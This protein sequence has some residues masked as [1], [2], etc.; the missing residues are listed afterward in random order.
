MPPQTKPRPGIQSVE[1][2]GR[3][4]RALAEAGRPLPLKDLAKLARMHPGKCH[5]Y[6]V[7]LTRIELVTQD[8]S[9]GYYG[10]GPMAM[11]LGLAGLRNVDVVRTATPLLPALRDEVNETALLSIWSPKGPVVFTLEESERPVY[12]NVKVGS[13]LPL[14]TTA[15]GRVFA[16]F[17]PHDVTAPLLAEELRG[18]TRSPAAF[19]RVLEDVRRTGLASI[20]GDLVPGVNAVAAPL[21]DRKDRIVGVIGA[22][23]RS[24]DLDVSESGVVAKVLLRTAFEISRRMGRASQSLP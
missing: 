9:S 13:I 4:L 12:F 3:I 2:A 17:L 10:V 16:A 7:S 18:S 14:T 5:R 11:M 8:E 21:F 23:G 20:Q 15:T 6:L 19:A 24:E 22:L 1:V